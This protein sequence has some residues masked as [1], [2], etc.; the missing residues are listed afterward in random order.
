MALLISGLIIWKSGLILKTTGYKLI[1]DFNTIN[2]LLMGGDVRYRG[3]RV[4]RVT[5]ITPGPKSIRV[6]FYVEPGTKIPENSELK[7]IFDGLIGEKYISIVPNQNTEK[8][9][10]EGYVFHGYS[11]SGLAD[12][13]D[14]GTK[15][16]EETKA[17]LETL[18]A[19]ITSPEVGG[20]LKN[21]ILQLEKITSNLN[22]ITS[23][24]DGGSNL[25]KT[26]DNIRD[27]SET[28]KKTTDTLFVKG[29]MT[30]QM[31]EISKSLNQTMANLNEI[32]GQIKEKDLVNKVDSTLTNLENIS[33]KITGKAFQ[34]KPNTTV[35]YSTPE[36]KGYYEANMDIQTDPEKFWRIGFGNRLGDTKFLNLQQGIQFNKRASARFG[37]I[38]NQ[39]GIG[40]DYTFTPESSISLQAFNL[41]DL[42]FDA[43]GRY[44]IAK[45]TDL[46]IHFLKNPKTNIHDNYG[47]GIQYRP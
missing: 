23:S 22:Q 28:L 8:M 2:G 15:N 14:V 38:N 18:R 20:A 5:E 35:F 39:P 11:T 32:T 12:F 26:L 9:A 17:I 16:L 27:I 6:V 7:V 42:E 46:T 3:Y 4:G 43:T 21:T 44:Q 45:K 33:G 34:F 31:A 1:G 41:N 36:K 25:K 40:V 37:L 24:S 10:E 29:N 30:E 19:I 13:V 47:I